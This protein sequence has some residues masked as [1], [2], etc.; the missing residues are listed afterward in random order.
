MSPRFTQNQLRGLLLLLLFLLIF[1]GGIGP[2]RFFRP[3]TR[4][5]G[6]AA[7][8]TAPAHPAAAASASAA[9]PAPALPSVDTGV[10]S[11]F[12][13]WVHEYVR[14]AATDRRQSLLAQGLALAQSRRARMERLI[15]EDPEQAIA[16]ALSF[17]EW[18]ALPPE[19]RAL[20]EKPFSV[21][22][23]Y[24]YYPVCAAQGQPLP[25]NTPDHIADIEMGD[26]RSLN[27]YVYGNNRDLMSKRALPV[28]GVELGGQAAI[29]D[30]ACQQL[31]GRDLAV[32]RTLF[33]GGH[34]DGTQSDDNA[35]A[36]GASAVHAV[37]GGTLHVFGDPAQFAQ[38]N[39]RISQLNSLPG[40]LAATSLLAL[41]DALGTTGTI[42]WGA[43]ETL[44]NEQAS[45][46]TE[47]KKTLMLIR[48]NFPDKLAEPVTQAAATS[49][50]N[51]PSS[52][53]ILAMSYGKTWVE[54]TVSANLYTLPQS[55]TYY[56]NSG[57]GLN[58]ELLRDAR[59]TFRNTKSG[60][61][62]S[63]NIGPVSMSSNGDGGG[64]G[65]YDIVAVFFTS[66]G[67]SSGG[68][69][70][71]GLA[72]G[73]NLW[74]QNANYTSL[75]THEWGHNYGL[76][77]AS[78]WNTTDGSV[79]GTGT[80]EEYGDS[81]DVLG[82]GPAPQGHYHPQA[83]VKLNWLTSSQWSDAT[84]AGSNTYRIYREDDPATTGNPRGVRVTKV[85]T[86]GSEE[87]Y[88]IGYKPAFTTNPH[89]LRGAY[90]NWQQAGQTRCWLLDTTPNSTDGKTDAPVDLGRTYAD[91]AA[92]VF[93]TP[94]ASGGSGSNSYLDVRV[95]L[96]PYPTNHA[97]TAAAISGPGSVAARSQAGFAVTAADAD[98]DTLAYSWNTLDGSVNDNS[99]G[100][101]HWWEVGGTYNFAVTV[102]DMKGGTVT[103]NKSITVTDPLDTWTQQGIG[104]TDNLQD[105]VWG[106]G[107]FVAAEYW[108]TV[109]T[110]WDGVSWTNAGGPPAFD[111][112]PRLAFGNNV[113]VMAGKKDNVS[114]AQIC[115][116]AD[117]RMWSAA[118]FP[119]GIPQIQEVAFGNGKFLA[120]ADSGTVVSSADGSTW[121]LTTVGG[122]PN[123]RHLT[124]DGSV[125]AA[126]A[127]NA[128]QSRTEVV[129]T[130][131]DGV[132]WTQRA[133]LG[134]DTYRIYGVGGVMYALGWY[135]GVTVSMDHGVTWS[136]ASTPGS[137]RW[138]TMRMAVSD[139][140]TFLITAKAMDESGTPNALLVSSDGV[141]WSR[142]T[143][144]SGNTAVGNA[145]GLV[146]GRGRFLTVENSGTARICNTFYPTNSDPVPAFTASPSTASARQAVVI[147]ASATDANGD[148]LVYAWDY[149]AQYPI[150]D[151][152]GIAARFDCG[153]SF[154]VTLRVSDNHGGLAVLSYS[155]SVTDPLDTWTQQ[156][157]GSTNDLQ[158]V[159]WGK[160]RFVAAEYWGTVY[161][162]WDGASWTNAG[163]PP[164]FD[165]QPHLA[166]GNNVFV[167]AGKKDN[168]SAAQI[169]YSAD[170]RMW[171]AA[172]FPAGI[173][174]IQEVAFG[175]GKFLAVADS[176]TV[177]SSADGST[178]SLT[179]VG[180][181]PNFRHLAWD[182]S[183]WA[184]VAMNAAQSRP[185][186]VWTSL[187]GVTWTQRAALGFDTYRIYGVG[188]VMYALG[189]YGGVTV[190]MDHGVTW[191]AAST[192]GST[193]W[194]TLRMAV[195]DEGT[196]LITAKAMDEAGAPNALLVSSN[197]VH[198]SRST[199]NSGNTAVGNA[200]GLV[201]GAGA[202]LTVENSGFVR[203]CNNF[204]PANT[205][206][207][208][209]FTLN[210]ASVAA[211]QVVELTASAS[212]ANGDALVYAWD[213]GGQFPLLD[214]ARIA[215]RFDFGGSYPVTL[216][217]SDG[218]GGLATLSYSLTVTD[219]ARTFSQRS[220]GTTH[221]LYAIAANNSLAVAVGGSGGTI[222]TS[223]DGV[224]WTPRGVAE[225]AGNITFRSA[226]W[227][228]S[229]F[230][231]AGSDYN[232]T[233]P[234]GGQGVI[235]TSTDG[236]TW[237]RRYGTTGR[238]DEL[239]AVASDGT[240]AV[241]VGTNGNVLTSANGTVW[242]SATIA[243]L[244]TSTLSGV[245]WHG[246][247]YALVGYA[248]GN[249]SAK[250]FTSAD[251]SNWFDDSAGAGVASWQDL[252]K[253][254]WMN[255][256]FVA[257]GWYSSLRVSTDN[258]QTFATTRGVTEET[259]AM[260]YGDGI[261]FAAG[262]NH[263]ASDAAVDVLSRDGLTWYSFAAPTTNRNGAAFFKHALITVGDGG[264]IWQSG[265]LT[266]A[267]GFV[268]WQ[269]SYFPAGG[270]A[271]LPGSDADADGIPNLIEYAL[272][273]DPTRGAANDGPSG[274]GH[275][276]T[277]SAS[278]WLHL[279]MPDPAMADVTYVVQGGT[280]LTGP[281]TS[282]AS[283][284][285]NANWSWQGGGTLRIT[286]GSS[287]GGRLPVDVG[288]P[289]S[290]SGQPRYFLR[291][292]ATVP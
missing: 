165:N 5:S 204:Y 104:S 288:R 265:N 151:G 216:R 32:A 54:G 43:L 111:N 69:T 230:I 211:R 27:A 114:A 89:F 238:S 250:V 199:A 231:I 176:G 90:L 13:Q 179:T 37:I 157:I 58:S 113:F 268:A 221:N 85:A 243:G 101:S 175:N 173:P 22:A 6:A 57:S 153:G 291:L 53:M 227:D 3:H 178:W 93:I 42:N 64:L 68:I 152:P 192:P 182:G 24:H 83:K 150:L 276:I 180:G 245:A 228:G 258:A 169:C 272:A 138:S 269:N 168:V 119:A 78:S 139:E 156:S 195:S 234:A 62:A 286:Q 50:I 270:I 110:S 10:N 287:S 163:G 201:F 28:Q 264:S 7:A 207:L 96:G 76:G 63:I 240:G 146:F 94:L 209:A 194:S 115:Y 47:T 223:T 226:I 99:P 36:I 103:L 34:N 55:S 266:P 19:V 80:S 155:I 177:V 252:R 126:V 164:A 254:A 18:D 292:Q 59:N 263:S 122:T 208:P 16:E 116:S 259:P 247:V 97:P 172:A 174:Q 242:S 237:T 193:R 141:H 121:S 189:W 255:D 35:A 133:A 158:E 278:P 224:S 51:G 105:V 130:S 218:H 203:V 144:N 225:Y 91:S 145:N 128:A 256:R 38:C 33:G 40:P 271:A 217:V 147:S 140:G 251:R 52:A 148:P 284:N 162:S 253:I 100:L 106:K 20:V 159:V 191:S 70:Y 1:V 136:A 154:P 160:G 65:N 267:S 280:S 143:A 66:I 84:A 219:P 67:M 25:P 149:G 108:G 46:W 275:L 277:I 9:R 81:F 206:P 123:L 107:R 86:P 181:T 210:P 235:H 45:A 21:T 29:R 281:W 79:V 109:Y 132:T 241:A 39:A 184:A 44:A 74:V 282:L 14:A 262:V 290:A 56:Y 244:A 125:W 273:R 170:G 236:I 185:E 11:G 260:A 187:D 205:P 239:N 233:A 137:T 229:K 142:S 73:G 98:G 129:W 12:H 127:M 8:A 48:A 112:Q 82:S 188:G 77:H 196:F 26:G 134:F 88:W 246:G 249:G 274:A 87:Y 212:D 215:P 198:W 117:G 120:V 31:A 283:K 60:G 222:L 131:L 2:R 220:S 17:G 279:D 186:V 183:V 197:G 61:D 75:Y 95:N 72:G 261:Y 166:F 4:A 257:S 167:M 161:T 213:F 92:N 289:D 124:W 30:G 202:F 200:N 171:S 102:S 232:F 285:G 214:G 23:D 118:A 135:G 71:A 190:S 41:P 49:E 248:G 15:R